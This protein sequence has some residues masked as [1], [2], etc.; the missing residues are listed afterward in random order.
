MTTQTVHIHTFDYGSSLSSAT[1]R[2]V[3]DDTLVATA[4][5]VNEVTADSGLYAAVFGEIAVIAAGEYRLRAIVSGKPINRYVTLAGTDNEVVEARSER[6]AVL[7]SASVDA[8][9][10]GIPKV[11]E[12]HRY[13][14]VASAATT[15]DV[16]IGEAT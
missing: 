7:D 13:T 2:N 6:A 16:S 9:R 15:T 1:L 11:G 5:T 8:I 12:T 3:A 4:D 10:D 14:Q